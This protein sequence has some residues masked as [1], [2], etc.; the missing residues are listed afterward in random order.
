MVPY[1]IKDDISRNKP[2]SLF[3]KGKKK[4]INPFEEYVENP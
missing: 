4:D 1:E 2:K 3:S